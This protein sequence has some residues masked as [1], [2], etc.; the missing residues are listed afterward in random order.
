MRLTNA[1][2]EN[3]VFSALTAA[4]GKQLETSNKEVSDGIALCYSEIYA[5]H[6]AVVAS[7]PAELR[8]SIFSRSGN[9]IKVCVNGTQ[10]EVLRS[11]YRCKSNYNKL[12]WPTE[13]KHEVAY[14][15]RFGNLRK[16]SW[17][18]EAM[19]INVETCPINYARMLHVRNAHVALI[20]QIEA[21]GT[22]LQSVLKCATTDTKLLEL[23]PELEPYIPTPVFNKTNT[24]LVP[25]DVVNSVRAALQGVQAS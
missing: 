22:Q 15:Y 12:N 1:M 23:A 4:F 5:A 21:L 25:L 7:T 24:G 2:R 16:D 10:L 6:M 9:K 3:I 8:E 11:V 20:G 17:S 13:E 14:A 19:A 18:S